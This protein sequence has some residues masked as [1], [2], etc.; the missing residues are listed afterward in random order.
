MHAA[1]VLP[2][3]WKEVEVIKAIKKV[4]DFKWDLKISCGNAE[5]TV[6]IDK[7][8]RGRPGYFDAVPEFLDEVQAAFQRR[9]DQLEQHLASYGFVLTDDLFHEETEDE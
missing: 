4:I 9:Y 2:A 5:L 3:L 6:N 7:S 1:T 8:L